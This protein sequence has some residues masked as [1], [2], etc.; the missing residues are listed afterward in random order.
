MGAQN[1]KISYFILKFHY[2]YN[3]NYP[4]SWSNYF[5]ARKTLGFTKSL[6][7]FLLVVL[8]VAHITKICLVYGLNVLSIY[9]S[10]GGAD[11]SGTETTEDNFGDL[12]NLT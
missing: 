6:V 1:E 7:T 4:A 9:W 5:I 8:Y 10:V 2:V 3:F 12:S 11:D